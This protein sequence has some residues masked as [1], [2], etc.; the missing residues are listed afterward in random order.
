MLISEATEDI[1]EDWNTKITQR[2]IK[3]AKNLKKEVDVMFQRLD[4]IESEK[5][6]LILSGYYYLLQNNSLEL[7]MI[8]ERM[9]NIPE[10]SFYHHFF[11]GIRAYNL[12]RYDDALDCYRIA[13]KY[14]NKNNPI[15]TAEFYY[16]VAAVYYQVQE[17]LMS[18]NLIQKALEVFEKNGKYRNRLGD[19]RMLL[20]L[21][22]IDMRQFVEAEDQFHIAR[23]I[24]QRINDSGL[25]ARINH[26]LG[27][28]YAEQGLS[29]AAVRYLSNVLRD[30]DYDYS[31]SYIK[32]IF[33][34]TREYFKLNQIDAGKEW[35]EKG[36]ALAHELNNVEYK[37]KFTLLNALH[38]DNKDFE[39]TFKSGIAYLQQEKLWLDIEEYAQIFARFYLDCKGYQKAAEYYEIAIEAKNEIKKME[40][41]K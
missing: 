8:I 2:N 18:V 33:L 15:E 31:E 41:L 36:I 28:M 32:T 7:K 22:Y 13:E 20:G 14:L 25:L 10:L 24:A 5:N 30:E 16:R 26:N 23:D 11:Q 40:G 38:L 9:G 27:F 37:V 21:N 4:D 1:L 35:Y 34:L 3:E 6:Y 17:T 29:E 19:C 39:S 12:R